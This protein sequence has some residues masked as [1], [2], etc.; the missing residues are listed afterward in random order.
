MARE[1]YSSVMPNILV[2]D[3][4]MANCELISNYLTTFE[5]VNVMVS[6]SG[7]LALDYFRKYEYAL[8][9]LDVD[10][11]R[12]DGFEL[13][14]EM[15]K[16]KTTDLTPIIYITGHDKNSARATIGYDLGA[17]DYILKPFDM[18][19]LL[20]KV[21]VFL[22]LYHQRKL[23][24]NEVS[25]KSASQTALI[26]SN[27]M[28]NELVEERY[29]FVC[30]LDVKGKV[31]SINV[32]SIKILKAD[33]LEYVHG[34]FLAKWIFKDDISVFNDSISKAIKGIETKIRIR[35]QTTE[36]NLVWLQLTITPK[37]KNGQIEKL[38]C[39]GQDISEITLEE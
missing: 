23:L 20:K 30:A 12:M 34:A 4:I 14:R 21:R 39:I 13:I 37:S 16:I 18:E 19:F 25:T 6:T 5:K 36:N 1:K 31:E 10:M 26:E 35:F 33:S 2:V 27:S 8:M 11:P 3:D 24:E 22:N 15:K 9:L 38:Y 17:V 29:E 32:A 7:W 28:I